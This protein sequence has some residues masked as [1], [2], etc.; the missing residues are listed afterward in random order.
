MSLLPTKEKFCSIQ[1][2]VELRFALKPN[3]KQCVACVWFFYAF[4]TPR[5]HLVYAV[6]N[7][8][9][10]SLVLA[11]QHA[12]LFTEDMCSAYL[13]IISFSNESLLGYPSTSA[14][15]LQNFCY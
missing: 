9:G 1:E 2:N 11:I 4:C 13:S 3:T 10:A 5:D 8:S 7:F 6:E 14:F 15:S 12:C